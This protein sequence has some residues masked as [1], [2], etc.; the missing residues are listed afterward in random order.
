MSRFLMWLVFQGCIVADARRSL[1]VTH[2]EDYKDESLAVF[3]EAEALTIAL[4][5]PLFSYMSGSK[6]CGKWSV[7]LKANEQAES[8]VKCKQTIHKVDS[9]FQSAKTLKMDDVSD[10]RVMYSRS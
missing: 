3:G 2:A 8:Y 9:E 7:V 4:F 10:P 1:M 6:T 5:D